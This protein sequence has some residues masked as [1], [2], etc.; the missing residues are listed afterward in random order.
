MVYREP[1]FLY[2]HTSWECRSSPFGEKLQSQF[3]F[4]RIRHVEKNDINATTT[5]AVDTIT[6]TDFSQPLYHNLPPLAASVRTDFLL[7]LIKIEGESGTTTRFVSLM[8]ATRR[9]VCAAMKKIMFCSTTTA[10]IRWVDEVWSAMM[11]A[12]R[13]SKRDSS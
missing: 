7:F 6:F 8:T 4:I 5:F 2:I 10:A 12:L 9:Q 1:T 3:P 11:L 13:Y